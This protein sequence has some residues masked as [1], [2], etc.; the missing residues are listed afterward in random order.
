MLTTELVLP[1]AQKPPRGEALEW[2][3]GKRH[4]RR[5]RGKKRRGGGGA[6]PASGIRAPASSPQTASA[7][8]HKPGKTER[9]AASAQPE[10]VGA[11]FN[12]LVN[13]TEDDDGPVCLV[14]AI[15]RKGPRREE[16]NMCLSM[17]PRCTRHAATAESPCGQVL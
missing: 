12:G 5:P 1:I 7:D 16:G 3:T 11:G 15:V 14:A 4:K 6:S 10:S 17:F 2:A 8:T 9:A 13:T